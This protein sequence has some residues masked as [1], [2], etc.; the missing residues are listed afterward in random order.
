MNKARTARQIKFYQKISILC[1]PES[2]ASNEEKNYLFQAKQGLESGETFR[3]V[4]ELLLRALSA[5]D[6]EEG[7]TPDVK[8]LFE[9]IKEIYGRPD[10]HVGAGTSVLH[11]KG[12]WKIQNFIFITFLILPILAI[13]YKISPE[14]H[15]DR[16]RELLIAG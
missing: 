16:Y 11:G 13:V 5:L 12:D 8:Q 15:H 14:I 10:N 2:R 4:I 6:S 7:L 3:A 1:L 9:D